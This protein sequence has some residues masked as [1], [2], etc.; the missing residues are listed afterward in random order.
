PR[1]CGALAPTKPS[2][3]P[4]K[5]RSG[6]CSRSLF[7]FF[8][9]FLSYFLAP[10]QS[11]C[12]KGVFPDERATALSRLH[13]ALCVIGSRGGGRVWPDAKGPELGRSIGRPSNRKLPGRGVR[14]CLPSSG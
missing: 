14:T 11:R 2:V 8:Q 13:R 4:L 7:L 9:P 3:K 1:C 12:F 6:L 5:R 10:S